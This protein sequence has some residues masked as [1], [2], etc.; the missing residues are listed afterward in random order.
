MVVPMGLHP[1]IHATYQHSMV[2]HSQLLG[3]RGVLIG[4]GGHDHVA[5]SAQGHRSLQPDRMRRGCAGGVRLEIGSWRCVSTAAKGNVAVC[6]ARLGCSG[7]LYDI[8]DVGLRLLGILV[9]S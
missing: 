7:I 1:G 4:N 6:A 3:D 5:H 9:A 8:G 2:Q